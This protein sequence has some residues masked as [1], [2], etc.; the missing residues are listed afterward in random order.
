MIVL[1]TDHLSVLG[2]PNNAHAA[3]L[4]ARMEESGE[5]DFAISIVTVEEQLRG[6]LSLIVLLTAAHLTSRQHLAVEMLND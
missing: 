3:A 4:I 6:W 1:D 2:Y 5:T